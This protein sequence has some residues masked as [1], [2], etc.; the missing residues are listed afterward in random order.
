[1]KVTTDGKGWRG[2]RER[3]GDRRRHGRG[4]IREYQ[5]MKRGDAACVRGRE[6]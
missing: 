3:M 1:L 5:G 4:H 6:G 2:W